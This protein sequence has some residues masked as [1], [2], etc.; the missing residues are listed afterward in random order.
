[1][2]D[3]L[4][5]LVF[6]TKMNTWR[7]KK[8]GV[9]S[10]LLVWIAVVVLY[11]LYNRWENVHLSEAR[12]TFRSE[13]VIDG[14]SNSSLN[15]ADHYCNFVT[16]NLTGAEGDIPESYTLESLHIL[17]RHGDRGPMPY[18]ST[19]RKINCDVDPK[20]DP[21]NLLKNYV[22]LRENQQVRENLLTFQK[23]GFLPASKFC[24]P[25][26]LSH[27]GVLQHLR[28][29]LHLRKKYGNLLKLSDLD[30][31]Q[32]LLR[33]TYYQRTFQSLIALMTSFLPKFDIEKVQIGRSDHLGF[34]TASVA[35][36]KCAAAD[37]YHVQFKSENRLRMQAKRD[38]HRHI[39][40]IAD[41]YNFTRAARAHGMLDQT[42][43]HYCHEAELPCKNGKCL[44]LADLNKLLQF[45]IW[46]SVEMVASEAYQQYSAYDMYGLLREISYRLGNSTLQRDTTLV[47]KVVVYSGH[48]VTLSPFL[49]ALGV[50]DGIVPPYASRAIIELLRGK[51][52]YFIRVV[53][54]G[55][56]LTSGL[57]FCVGSLNAENLCPL[58]VFQGFVRGLDL[59]LD[60]SEKNCM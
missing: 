4:G 31:G 43:S 16:D 11:V 15:M 19:P 28:N 39:E 45:Y 57:K 14:S 56:D 17:I 49:T 22:T 21:G 27:V 33:S 23:F 25:G 48:D 58:H 34:C 26:Q 3:V 1:M 18:S 51:D 12:I 59:S 32:V 13:L 41:V 20:D 40:M 50:Y 38:M 60:F 55:V 36:C 2:A 54:N 8:L 47:H 53:Y 42:M 6:T 44:T 7:C 29:G 9:C 35:N 52:G 30:I 37:R 24:Q 10:L 5:Y 46:N